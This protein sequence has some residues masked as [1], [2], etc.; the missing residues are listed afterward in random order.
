MRPVFV[1]RRGCLPSVDDPAMQAQAIRQSTR[2]REWQPGSGDEENLARIRVLDFLVWRKSTD[3]HISGIRSMRAGDES[4]FA[5]NR[6]AIRNGTRRLCRYRRWR[7]SRRSRLRQSGS[8]LRGRSWH[9]AGSRTC[10]GVGDK[11]CR[12]ARGRLIAIL[13]SPGAGRGVVPFARA[14][15]ILAGREENRDESGR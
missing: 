9:A 7:W 12:G 10:R 2:A 15:L 1:T 5:G 11:I 8:R 3:V 14:S 4:R 13:I 6:R